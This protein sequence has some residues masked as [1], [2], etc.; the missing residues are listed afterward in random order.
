MCLSTH[1]RKAKVTDHD[2]VCYKVVTRYYRMKRGAYKSYWMSYDYSLGEHYYERL[3]V[4]DHI[5]G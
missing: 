1:W 4:P 2:I 5:G 3:L